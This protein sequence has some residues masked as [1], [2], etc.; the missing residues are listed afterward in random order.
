MFKIC[1]PVWVKGVG[2]S[3]YLGVGFEV[4]ISRF[5]ER[6]GFILIFTL[7]YPLAV[8]DSLEVFVLD[9]SSTFVRVSSFGPPPEGLEDSS[10]YLV[11][12][13]IA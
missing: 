4:G 3:F 13:S 8:F 5:D 1:F 10:V 11:E 9:P 7:E 2:F 6:P 12:G